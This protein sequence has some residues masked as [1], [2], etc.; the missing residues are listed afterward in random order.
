[1]LIDVSSRKS[2][3]VAF[4]ACLP[5]RGLIP[6]LVNKSKAIFNFWGEVL[7]LLLNS[8]FPKPFE[9]DRSLLLNNT[10]CTHLTAV[11]ELNQVVAGWYLLKHFAKLNPAKLS[12]FWLIIL[13][14][15]DPTGKIQ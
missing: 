9:S 10:S 7:L 5:A 4:I 8:L 11:M 14:A 6:S 12:W 3:T 2:L 15:D 13:R 1:M